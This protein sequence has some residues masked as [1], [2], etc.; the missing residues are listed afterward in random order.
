M[1]LFLLL[2]FP[3]FYHPSQEVNGYKCSCLRRVIAYFYYFISLGIVRLLFHWFPQ[4]LLYCKYQ[5][6]PLSEAT[7]VL[8]KVCIPFP[9]KLTD[10]PPSVGWS[11][12]FSIA[13]CL[14]VFP[15]QDSCGV[16][17]VENI[18]YPKTL[19]MRYS[20]ATTYSPLFYSQSTA[21]SYATDTTESQGIKVDFVSFCFSLPNPLPIEG[22]QC[23][24][25]FHL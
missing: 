10:Q 19:D 5:K 13:L 12:N 2:V 11:L 1:W 18:S 21:E 14:C 25:L 8:I 24:G 20:C 4:W 16:F 6:C 23:I 22:R 17:Y 7:K 9:R 15:F 3:H